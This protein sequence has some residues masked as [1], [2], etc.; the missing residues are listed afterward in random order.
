MSLDIVIQEHCNE[1]RDLCTSLADDHG[2]RVREM[3]EHAHRSLE[4]RN[5]WN[6]FTQWLRRAVGKFNEAL[7]R[8]WEAINT[9]IEWVNDNVLP[10]VFGPVY[11]AKSWTDWQLVAEASGRV[12]GGMSIDQIDVAI[13]W[14]GPAASSYDST[15]ADQDGA[16]RVLTTMVQNLQDFLRD[17]LNGLIDFLLKM[18]TMFTDMLSE[19]VGALIQFVGVVNPLTWGEILDKLGGFIGTGIEQIGERVVAMTEYVTGGMNAM[20]DVKM[21]AI[22]VHQLPGGGAEWPPPAARMTAQPP[23]EPGGPKYPGWTH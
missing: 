14:Q 7:G 2:G 3:E 4:D 15:I 12:T 10:W 1:L 11:L 8:V 19:A 17:H 21:S 6:E 13:D 16:G 18:V 9:A 20:A 23:S 5:W 22:E